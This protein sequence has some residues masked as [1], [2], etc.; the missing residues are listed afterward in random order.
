M[1][2]ADAGCSDIEWELQHQ[3]IIQEEESSPF[4]Q[5]SD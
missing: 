5:D 4:D 1:Y 2:E 3:L